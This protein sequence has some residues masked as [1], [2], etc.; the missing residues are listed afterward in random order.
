MHADPATNTKATPSVDD[1]ESNTKVLH[2]PYI[3]I[4]VVRLYVCV[5]VAIICKCDP[6]R[7]NPE[8]G[9]FVTFSTFNVK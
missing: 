5:N 1:P 2:V 9:S 6:L 3:F 4:D 7:Q 8:Q